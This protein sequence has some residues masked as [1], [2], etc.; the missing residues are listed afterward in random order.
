MFQNQLMFQHKVFISD[1]ADGDKIYDIFYHKFDNSNGELS[2]Y[3]I[4]HK[5]LS[6]L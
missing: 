2:N 5:R 1:G 3:Q 4:Y 6:V